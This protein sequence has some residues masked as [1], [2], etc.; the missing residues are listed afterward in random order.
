MYMEDDILFSTKDWE[1]AEMLQNELLS[2]LGSLSP[3]EQGTLNQVTHYLS[4]RDLS[5]TKERY[6]N[7]GS[8]AF[9]AAKDERNSFIHACVDAGQPVC[10]PSEPNQ[11]AI[12]I[13]QNSFNQK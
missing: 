9:F 3:E 8:D 4:L 10:A 7:K 5:T 13:D 6:N 2:R 12:F 1:E 11:P